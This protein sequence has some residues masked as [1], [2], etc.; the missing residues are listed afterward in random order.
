MGK[1]TKVLSLH[2]FTNV[3]HVNKFM[4]LKLCKEKNLKVS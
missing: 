1:S 2:C 3:K 4:F